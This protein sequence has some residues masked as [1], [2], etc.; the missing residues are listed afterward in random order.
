MNIKFINTNLWLPL[1]L[2][3]LAYALLG[4]YLS[5]YHL[6]WLIGAFVVAVTLA[7]TRKS[8]FWLEPLLKFACQGMAATLILSLILSM[9]IA[10]VTTNASTLIS[11]IGLIL[12]TTFFSEIAMSFAGFNKMNTLLFLILLAGFGLGLG[13]IIDVLVFPSIRY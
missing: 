12:L 11:L 1:V 3:W 7:V 8:R 9:S 6:I 13:E 10:L 5:A 4:W 2:L